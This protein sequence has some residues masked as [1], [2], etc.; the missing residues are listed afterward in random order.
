MINNSLF[1]KTINNFFWKNPPPPPPFYI[2]L[3][4]NSSKSDSFDVIYFF[5]DWSFGNPKKHAIHFFYGSIHNKRRKNI[6]TIG[7]RRIKIVADMPV[8]GGGGGGYSLSATKYSFFFL[9]EKNM[10]KFLKRKNM[11]LE[12]ISSYF[13]FSPQIHTF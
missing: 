10:Q 8:N 7:E 11:Y 5:T 12:V 9:K 2:S 13:E 4:N 3:Y 6:L 1:Y